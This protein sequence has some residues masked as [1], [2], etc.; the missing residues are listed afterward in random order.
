MRMARV[1]ALGRKIPGLR[2]LLGRT[3]FRLGLFWVDL[4]FF[5]F[6]LLLEWAVWLLRKC[7]KGIRGMVCFHGLVCNK[8]NKVVVDA[9][10][11]FPFL[12]FCLC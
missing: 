10:N 1:E 11:C 9:E 7:E 12:V 4:V 6:V 8:M 3:F 5:V 2:F